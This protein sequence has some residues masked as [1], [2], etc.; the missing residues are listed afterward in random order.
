M[1]LIN[2]AYSDE[3]NSDEADSS[4]VEPDELYYE[5]ELSDFERDYLSKIMKDRNWAL[6]FYS[7]RNEDFARMEDFYFKQHYSANAEVEPGG[8]MDE[9]T[10]ESEHLTVLPIAT[11]MVNTVHGLF[12]DEDPYIQC[13][14][15][16]GRKSAE[17]ASK[18]E[19]LCY[20]T[21]WINRQVNGS[22][23][24]GDCENDA[25]IYGWGCMYS[26]WDPLRAKL[27][28]TKSQGR[29]KDVLDFYAY[30]IVVRRIHPRDIYPLPWGVRERW[31][32]VLWIVNRTVREVEDEWG[33]KIDGDVLY[34]ENGN[35]LFD[36]NG[37]ICREQLDE[38]TFIEYIDY[39]SWVRE[40][41]DWCLYNAVVAH[42]QYVK[43]PTKMPEYEMLPYEIWF[44]R[45][46]PSDSGSRMG[47]SFL[48]PIIESVQEMEYLANRQT[49]MIDMYAD[50][51][52]KIID[53]AGNND[54][55]IEKGPG[56]VVYLNAGGDADYITWNGSPPDV[57]QLMR[58]WRE[59]AQD[60]FPPV[61]TGLSGGTSGI[62]TIALQQGGK[63]QTNKPRRNFELAMQRVNTKIIRLLQKFSWDDSIYVMGQRPKGDD[64]QPFAVTI[65]GRETRGFEYTT[66]TVRGRF[67]QEELRNVVVATQAVGAGIISSR[68]ASGKYMYVQD[69]D[70]EFL[71]TMQEQMI[72]DP[73]WREFFFQQYMSLPAMSPVTSALQ[74]E[75]S[76]PPNGMA[77]DLGGGLMAAAM[78][79]DQQGV[80]SGVQRTPVESNEYSR[81]IGGL[82]VA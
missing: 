18:T 2:E 53:M 19:A 15:A 8:T 58:M 79:Q 3:V 54:E 34:D 35:L 40:G 73:A 82:P 5:D 7:V 61:M 21:Y 43:L 6:Q 76:E 68:T 60:A 78:S 45:Q 65:K 69:P 16:T 37:D 25:L 67:P 51:M 22:D 12:T 20:G 72:K 39:W 59:M 36:E 31:R 42:N 47:L 29:P 52:L 30:P 41:D 13:V 75:P 1:V 64:I 71:L 32:G 33:V 57:S 11:N 49:R 27:S 4:E 23:P 10:D 9:S 62:D 48:Y 63:L 46:T 77:D 24:W 28:K 70:K 50:P 38:D 81:I 80:Q 74:E 55:D 66:V 44:C 26:Y 14:S 56:A 17:A